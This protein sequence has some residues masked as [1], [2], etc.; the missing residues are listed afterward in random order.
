VTQLASALDYLHAAGLV[1][2]DLKPANIILSATGEVTLLDLGIARSVSDK[3]G[4]TQTGQAIGT[5]AYMAPE[6]IT[7]DEITAAAD[8]YALGILTYEL[9]RPS[10][11][12]RQFDFRSP[13]P[14]RDTAAISAPLQPQTSAAGHAGRRTC[15]GQESRRSSAF[16][17]CVRRTSCRPLGRHGASQARK[18]GE[19]ASKRRLTART[20]AGAGTLARCG[21]D[22]LLVALVAGLVHLRL[23]TNPISLQATATAAPA[24]SSSVPLT[25]AAAVSS[26]TP[27]DQ[28]N[29][30]LNTRAVSGELPSGFSSHGVMPETPDDRDLAHHAVGQVRLNATGPEQSD[31]VDWVVF[32][33]AADAQALV[34]DEY[35]SKF[36]PPGFSSPTRCFTG[37]DMSASAA[38]YGYTTCVV[39]VG[40]TYVT[41]S[42]TLAAPALS[43]ATIPTRLPWP[44]SVLRTFRR[45][46]PR[47]LLR[48][49]PLQ[50]L[51]PSSRPSRS[52]RQLSPTTPYPR[53]ASTR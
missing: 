22:L 8:I 44:C 27:L 15:A 3:S 51:R 4:L 20:L 31:Y 24:S 12:Y 10:S 21:G 6:Q 39:L 14:D 7:G 18:R 45:C 43:V 1:H 48:A 17:D 30:L 13:R 52:H 50:P 26:L 2:R 25:T 28:Y 5:P 37:T 42:R 11:I 49:V 38:H 29:A 46:V 36:T 47:R 9:L 19:C 33:T 34:D 35:T 53:R 16:C 23:R 40:N 32:P 41:P